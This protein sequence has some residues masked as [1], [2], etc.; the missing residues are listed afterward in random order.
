M[1]KSNRSCDGSRKEAGSSL[2]QE[3]GL[4]T[5]P[6]A[7]GQIKLGRGQK[8]NVSIKRRQAEVG[9]KHKTMETTTMKTTSMKTMTMKTTKTTTKTRTT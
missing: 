6:G 8:K 5:H 3:I 9:H 2:G 4:I 1:R 7:A